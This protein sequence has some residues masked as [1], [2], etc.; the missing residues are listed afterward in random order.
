MS[1][2]GAIPDFS[3]VLLAGGSGTRMGGDAAAP[4]PKQYLRLGGKRVIDYS[5]DTFRKYSDDIV[6]VVPDPGDAAH[7]S[8]AHDGIR[9]VAGGAT[10]EDSVRNALAAGLRHERVLVHDAARPF[11]TRRVIADLCAELE[12][13]E[14]ACPVMPVV[15]SIVVDADG[16]L[17]RTPPR[18]DFHEI[19]TP[20]AFRADWLRRAM[21]DPAQVHPH[22]PERVR[23]LGGR[24]RHVRGTPWLFK[25]T[26]APDIHAANAH[27]RDY[28]EAEG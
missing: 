17:A 9:H 5:L 2:A 21:D 14:A 7:A 15:N 12:R 18:S 11:V 25:I 23:L 8:S 26:Y 1:E 27:W 16:L 20:Q 13:H 3:V 24:V 10:R 6:V 4:L 28:L 22:L 19:Q